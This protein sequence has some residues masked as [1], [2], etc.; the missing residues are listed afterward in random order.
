MKFVHIADM[1]FDIPFTTIAVASDLGGQ[2]RLEQRKVFSK[3]IDY[4][5]QNNIPYIFIS[6]DLYEH[7]YT[8]Q[9][10]IDYI[11]KLFKEIP[12]TKVFIAPGNHDPYIKNSYYVDYKWSDNVHIFVNTAEKQLFDHKQKEYISNTWTIRW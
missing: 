5:K 8:K 3:M 6:G 11:N 12:N 10:T 2:R 9:T 4:V 1:H 7:E